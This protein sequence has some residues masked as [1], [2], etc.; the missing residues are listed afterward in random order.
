MADQNSEAL[1]TVEQVAA[2]LSVSPQFIR[3]HATRCKP[4]I[5]CVRLGSLLRFRNGDIT[6]FIEQQLQAPPFRR[7]RKM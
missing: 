1:L 4:T 6:A 2:R 5:P 7:R 3:D